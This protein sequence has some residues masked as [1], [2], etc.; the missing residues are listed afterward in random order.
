MDD[1]KDLISPV[2]PLV[3]FPTPCN[4]TQ[5]LN[6]VRSPLSAG[7]LSRACLGSLPS[8]FS[9]ITGMYS[10]MVPGK[11]VQAPTL[12]RCI[13]VVFGRELVEELRTR[14]DE[15][16]LAP[17]GAQETITHGLTRLAEQSELLEPLRNEIEKSVAAD[18]WTHAAHPSMWKLDSLLRKILRFHGISLLSMGR[19]ATKDLTL[20]DR[21]PIIMPAATEQLRAGR[22]ALA[23]ADGPNKFLQAS[24]VI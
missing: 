2:S 20:R 23:I 13:V 24:N 22:L 1:Y 4:G 8:G 9:V 17:E 10:S 6:F 16:S 19:K 21:T 18:G 15:E 14:R 12:D 7:P 3:W 11:D 5:T